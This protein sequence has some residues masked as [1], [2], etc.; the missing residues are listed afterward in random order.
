MQEFREGYLIASPAFKER[1]LKRKQTTFKQYIFLTYEELHQRLFFKIKPKALL[2]VCDRYGFGYALAEKYLEA[3]P[4][5]EDTTYQDP[6]LDSLVSVYRF[7]KQQNDLVEDP[8]FLL[9]LKQYPV[10]LIDPAE[11]EQ[12][13]RLIRKLKQYTEVFTFSSSEHSYRPTVY[14]FA[15]ME[16]E[17]RFVVTE[18]HRL[19]QNGVDKNHI[20]LAGLDQMTV[21]ILKRLANHYHFTIEFLPSFNILSTDFAKRFLS[22]L[23]TESSF[24]EVFAALPAD[25]AFYDSVRLLVETYELTDMAPNQTVSFFEYQFKKMAY[26][27]TRYQDAIRIIDTDSL[28]QQQ[29]YL[30]YMGFNLGQAPLIR[31][32]EGFL[33]DGLKKRIGMMTSSEENKQTVHHLKRLIQ[34]IPQVVLTYKKASSTETFLPSFLIQELQLEVKRPSVCYGIAQKEDQL[35]LSCYYDAYLKYGSLH[36]DLKRYGLQDASY[37]AFDHRYRPLSPSLLSTHFQKKPLK[38]AYSNLKLYYAC[39]FRYYADRIL[40]LNAFSSELPTRLGTFA[41]AVLEESYTEDFDFSK[42]VKK[43]KVRY[44]VDRKDDFFFDRMEEVLKKLLAF[45]QKKE[46]ASQLKTIRTEQHIVIEKENY[47]FEGYIDKLM[48]TQI[49][50]EIYAVLIDYKTGKDVLSLD[51]VED[52]FH[53]QLPAYMYLLSCYEPFQGKKLHIIGIYLQKVNLVV[54]DPLLDDSPQLEKSFKLQGYSLADPSLLSLFDPSYSDSD[55]IQ[56]LGLSKTTNFF[57][58][59]SKIFTEEDQNNLIALVK[60]LIEEASCQIH[61]GKFPIAPKII[62][63]KNESCAF[64]DYKDLCFSTVGDW[65]EL[66]KKPFKE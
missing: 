5:V 18:I 51:N 47:L 9:R 24:N 55:Y 1:F 7:L 25:S 3:I 64:C 63:G 26:P 17:C 53:L 39:P 12:T 28:L 61:Q 4:Y 58:S 6:T 59:Y 33:T 30:F 13:E 19:L 29:D 14:E 35:R 31:K 65:V 54:L 8:L 27:S 45:N 16:E 52:G 36:P 62:D 66:P 48:Y 57:K 10:T 38:L 2:S 23:K 32:E 15:T 44:A 50:D 21:F 56:S 22:L 37:Q 11:G 41:H 60:R 43:N 40:N 42:S 46:A 34:S 20:F 49:D